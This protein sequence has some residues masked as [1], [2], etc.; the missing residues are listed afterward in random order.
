MKQRKKKNF[1]C[2]IIRH[3]LREKHWSIEIFFNPTLDNHDVYIALF[4]RN[5]ECASFI[6]LCGVL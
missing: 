4:S 1:N 3:S 6:M 5:T 2:I